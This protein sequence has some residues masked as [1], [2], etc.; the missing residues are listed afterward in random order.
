MHAA[1]SG[2][3]ELK[4]AVEALPIAPA[5]RGAVMR[6]PALGTTIGGQLLLADLD[7]LMEHVDWR[8]S[9]QS[10]VVPGLADSLTE[11]VRR[12]LIDV[13]GR[14]VTNVVLT[15]DLFEGADNVEGWTSAR[16]IALL[17]PLVRDPAFTQADKVG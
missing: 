2:A 10:P 8:L 15:G 5:A 9:E 12:Y 11:T 17:D 13:D 14:Q 16:L 6:V 7:L 1:P 3:V 4:Q